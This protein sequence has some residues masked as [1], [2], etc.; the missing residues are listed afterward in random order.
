MPAG[1]FARRGSDQGRAIR[2]GPA[3]NY[4]RA[5]SLEAARLLRDQQAGSAG[6]GWLRPYQDSV[7]TVLILEDTTNNLFVF[8][9][10]DE[11]IDIEW[12]DFLPTG[13]ASRTLLDAV[14]L[15][16][17]ENPELGKDIYQT[18]PLNITSIDR[19]IDKVR[20]GIRRFDP[21]YIEFTKGAN[22]V[23]QVIEDAR[24]FDTRLPSSIWGQT[25]DGF[26]IGRAPQNN[27]HNP[28][29]TDV[30]GRLVVILPDGGINIDSERIGN[31]VNA[32]NEVQESHPWVLSFTAPDGTSVGYNIESMTREILLGS[33]FYYRIVL[34]SAS[35]SHGFGDITNFDISAR[36]IT[37]SRL[38]FV[39]GPQGTVA[40]ES[41]LAAGAWKLA[42]RD[43]SHS[44]IE[45]GGSGGGADEDHEHDSFRLGPEPNTFIAD[46]SETAVA[47]RDAH[48]NDRANVAWVDDYLADSLHFI[49][50]VSPNASPPSM[51]AQYLHERGYDDETVFD[52][53]TEITDIRATAGIVK[54]TERYYIQFPAKSTDPTAAASAAALATKIAAAPA[55]DRIVLKKLS[56]GEFANVESVER[57]AAR[58]IERAFGATI[59]GV[60]QPIS[61][62]NAR[63]V[64]GDNAIILRVMWIASRA[65]RTLR[66][67][68]L[69]AYRR[70]G[71]P[72]AEQW[73]INWTTDAD[74]GNGV[75]TISETIPVTGFQT[76]DQITIGGTRYL[77][78]DFF[79]DVNELDHPIATYAGVNPSAFDVF[80]SLPTGAQDVFF[81]LR[82]GAFPFENQGS[83]AA[84]DWD[85]A[86]RDLDLEWV[87][88]S[89]LGVADVA[90]LEQVTSDATL[91]GLGTTASPLKVARALPAP[92][93]GKILGEE[94]GAWA[95]IDAPA[96]GGG[97]LTDEQLQDKVSNFIRSG[98]GIDI[99]YNDSAGTLTVS[100]LASAIGLN[101]EA[102]QDAV[103]ALFRWGNG[104]N[105]VYDDD[106][107]T[108]TVTSDAEFIRDTIAAFLTE[109]D[110]I[111]LTHNDTA[112]TLTIA[113]AGSSGGGGLTQE[114]VRD[115]VAGFVR[116]GD[117]LTITHDDSGN[118]LTFTAR[119]PTQGDDMPGTQLVSRNRL[120]SGGQTVP[121]NS[122]TAIVLD[123]RNAATPVLSFSFLTEAER[124]RFGTAVGQTRDL[125][126]NDIL[127]VGARINRLTRTSSNYWGLSIDLPRAF[128]DVANGSLISIRDGAQVISSD[129]IES[130][131]KGAAIAS[132]TLTLTRE[133]DTTLDLTLPSG[134]GGSGDFDLHDD[135]SLELA[136]NS[137]A[138]T[139]RMLFSDESASGDPNAYA[140]V[141]NFLSYVYSQLRSFFATRLASGSIADADR[142][143]LTD[144]S[145]SG[146]LKHATISDL[147]TVFASSGGGSGFDLHDDVTTE[148]TALATQDRVLV[149]DENVAGDP[150]RFATLQ[151]LA[152]WIISTLRTN[153]MTALARAGINDS[154]RIFLTDE[155]ETNDPL[156]H[157]TIGTLKTLFGSASTFDLH[158]DVTTRIDSVSSTDRLLLSDELTSG[159]PNVFM[160]VGQFF[161]SALV[162][163]TI[164]G[165]KTAS[166]L[167]ASEQSN[168]RFYFTDSGD[169][170]QLGFTTLDFLSEFLNPASVLTSST[171][172][173][174]SGARDLHGKTIY[175]YAP[176]NMSITLPALSAG[177]NVTFNVWNH[178]RV[179]SGTVTL[180]GGN[181]QNLHGADTVLRG[182]GTGAA[183]I[184]DGG[185]NRWEFSEISN[186]R[187]RIN[188][189]I[190][191]LP[192]N[193]RIFL[194]DED[195]TNDPLKYITGETL[196]EE[197]GAPDTDDG[198][199]R[200]EIVF[201]S[202]SLPSQTGSGTLNG[203]RWTKDTALTG[204]SVSTETVVVP[205]LRPYTDTTGIWAVAEN[206]S[207]DEVDEVFMP[208]GSAASGTPGGEGG[209]LQIG[210]GR[211]QVL[212]A[213][214]NTR[215]A[216]WLDKVDT[217]GNPQGHVIKLYLAKAGGAVPGT[218]ALLAA[219]TD[220]A[221]RGWSAKML[222]DYVGALTG[223][224][225]TP[226]ADHDLH[227][228]AI[229]A[230]AP[231]SLEG[232]T[233]VDIP[234]SEGSQQISMPLTWSGQRYLVFVQPAAVRDMSKLLAGGVDQTSGYRRG[235]VEIGG[236]DYEYL[237]S[238]LRA[239]SNVSGGIIFTVERAVS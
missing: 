134:G 189:E 87:G 234:A 231:T 118:T 114:Q 158:D 5:E 20:Q 230:A 100:I 132:N 36:Q 175:C 25:F 171:V 28:E 160:E 176:L 2:L 11:A 59:G 169:D 146:N 26:T 53:A 31:T 183:I 147:K 154:D 68:F 37:S 148:V 55:N 217:A 141:G 82:E 164:G 229:T 215:S 46:G 86:T 48:A 144:E 208:W 19:V 219:G 23:R 116:A 137:F 54:G 201:T 43:Q 187:D 196:K 221:I 62:G 51:V 42:D 131:F 150:N 32:F 213:V 156:K 163:L 84:G 38:Y 232:L 202:N 21:P 216:M 45:S 44:W 79:G 40:V 102:V 166:D 52:D 186:L 110:N 197:L 172:Y 95:A 78:V 157:T 98:T 22:T 159:D 65:N 63:I 210:G 88:I 142:M 155:S 117:Y 64:T 39:M 111:T 74:V 151:T 209:Y 129:N 1:G 113:A 214:E 170:G 180:T 161:R 41:R 108:L 61:P 227:F 206:A 153:A 121:P 204:F 236:T 135:V 91:T 90:G 69:A 188:V 101:L 178:S 60:V 27:N 93:S 4:F 165:Q 203:A 177:D 30:G 94:S 192:D 198:N 136:S 6:P 149:S 133:D 106:A 77:P 72:A 168:L 167:S 92:V 239:R 125:Y 205:E 24:R 89:G 235:T 104:I 57:V 152:A 195:S 16:G 115:L 184:W 47:K 145:D 238:T 107:G 50:L 139:D 182:A 10:Y 120:T 71:R 237:V 122:L 185:A 179:G 33:H 130:L 81:N 80:A 225:F 17:G 174:A 181:I 85:L 233:A 67:R 9:A 97:R 128:T 8:S 56:T 220:T 222:A 190:D 191:S 207:G 14:S 3:P 127:Y 103:A 211:I 58:S 143:F 96:G 224:T 223:G 75:E 105:G 18:I 123:A 73:Y 76:T 126:I 83:V 112:N 49:R 173:L 200:G 7:N 119:T 194:A 15:T 66:D 13:D 226:H 35:Y 34:A 138:G 193:A 212:Y 199:S 218:A 99:V 70:A 109:G 124:N 12:D 29:I 140:T 162:N 228:G